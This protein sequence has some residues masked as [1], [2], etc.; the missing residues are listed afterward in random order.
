MVV[1]AVDIISDFQT[2]KYGDGLRG[3]IVHSKQFLI[4]CREV[5]KYKEKHPNY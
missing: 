2:F 4:H 5:D 1:K 3:T